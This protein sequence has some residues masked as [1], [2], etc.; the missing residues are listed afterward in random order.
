M[1]RLRVLVIVPETGLVPEDA[2]KATDSEFEA[3]K[4]AYDVLH[5]LDALGHGSEQLGMWEEI[6]PLR[7]KVA[8]YQP[9][10]VFNLIDQFRNYTFYEQHI[11]SYLQLLRVPFT[12][13]NPRGL[14][15]ASDKALSKKILHYHRIRTP[16]FQVFPR[17]RRFRLS[18]LLRF[19]LIVKVHLEEASTGIAQ[20]S[21]VNNEEQLR[22]RIRFVHENFG[23]A[24][25]VEEYID[26]RELNVSVVGNH[27]LQVL[28]PWEL[29]LDDLPADVPRV[30]TEKVKW[31]LAYQ[32][33]HKI[34][35]GPARKLPPALQRELEQVSRRIYR[36]LNLSGYARIDYRLSEEG[37]LYF[38]EANANP[39]ISKDEEMASAAKAAGIGYE[40][41]IQKVLSLGRRWSA[42]TGL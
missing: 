34:R 9:S 28:P 7:R 42:E 32:K 10:I 5:A 4:A 14:V 13:C 19:P 25:V 11:V 23:V 1:K 26:G 29:F 22:D 40:V 3:F 12:G 2:A 18:K 33:K 27:R 38:L 20:A 17:S 6:A 37:K 15:L 24:A 16:R 36:A 31:D 39:D 41:L 30:A 8:D 35:I 21:V